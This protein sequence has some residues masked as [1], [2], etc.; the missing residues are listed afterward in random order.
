MLVVGV[1]GMNGFSNGKLFMK[2]MEIPEKKNENLNAI[3]RYRFF[4]VSWKIRFKTR[5]ILD[6]YEIH[7]QIWVA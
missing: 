6:K 2:N 3:A 1:Y 4:D 5:K 7:E